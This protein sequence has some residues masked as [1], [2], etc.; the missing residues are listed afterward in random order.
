MK[1]SLF[2]TISRYFGYELIKTKK[3]PTLD[4]HIHNLFKNNKINFVLDIGANRG[5]FAKKIRMLGYQGQIMSFEPLSQLYENLVIESSSDKKWTVFNI[6]FG[7]FKEE[8][9]INKTKGS[10][11]SSILMPNET[12]KDLFTNKMEIEETQNIILETLDSFYESFNLSGGVFLKTDTQGFDLNVLKGGAL[13][14]KKIN[15][16]LVETSFI[17]IYK[18]S[19]SFNEIYE[20]LNSLGFKLSGIYPVSKNT[21]GQ[22]IET[23]SLFIK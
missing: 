16:V 14:L 9:T 19:P 5:T 3:N 17:P 15:F 23:D 21:L 12:G 7:E 10:D 20:Y 6:G 1:K 8:V 4:S 11:L 13:C 18:N 2:R 22:I